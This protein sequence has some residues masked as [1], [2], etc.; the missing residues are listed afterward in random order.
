MIAVEYLNNDF[1]EGTII[2]VKI[3]NTQVTQLVR[4]LKCTVNIKLYF[5]AIQNSC[6][7]TFCLHRS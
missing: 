1:P 6:I 7:Q 4:T 3:R 2:Q 5:S